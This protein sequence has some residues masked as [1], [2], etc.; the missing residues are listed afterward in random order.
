MSN[1]SRSRYRKR[2]SIIRNVS[3]SGKEHLLGVRARD[4][5]LTILNFLS[6]VSFSAFAVLVPACVLFSSLLWI[7]QGLTS[8]LTG[9]IIHKLL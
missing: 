2:T 1:R 8:D 9:D 5:T 4:W 7:I 6:F 3:T